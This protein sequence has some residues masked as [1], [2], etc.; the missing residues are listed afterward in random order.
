MIFLESAF[1]CKKADDQNALLQGVYFHFRVA[2]SSRLS[3]GI[4]EV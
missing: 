2:A 4:Y 1:C 3:V